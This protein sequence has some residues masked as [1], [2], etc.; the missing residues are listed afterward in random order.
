[1]LFIVG[2]TVVTY[3]NTFGVPYL[4]DDFLS[5]RDNETIRHWLTA[6]SPPTGDGITVSGRPLLNFTF[7]LNY[8]LGGNAVVI[9]QKNAALGQIV[10]RP[11][12]HAQDR[13]RN[14]STPPM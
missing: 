10:E 3:A 6:W 4:F 12:S 5:I 9:G 7:A 2:A 1:M 11:G 8:A 14:T 13:G